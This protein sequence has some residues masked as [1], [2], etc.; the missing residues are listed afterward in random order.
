MSKW[1][2]FFTVIC[3]ILF[4]NACNPGFTK[5]GEFMNEDTLVSVI[6]DM[7]L[8]DAILFHPAIYNKPVVVNKSESYKLIL[9]K[10]SVD[11]GIFEKN[12]AYYSGNLPEFER[13]YEKVIEKLSEMQ[14]EIIKHDTLN[15]N[16]KN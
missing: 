1:F 3:I 10:H 13:I 9:K 14:G 11:S 4:P 16:V 12:I 8:C 7:H 15:T 5:T 6:A 2:L